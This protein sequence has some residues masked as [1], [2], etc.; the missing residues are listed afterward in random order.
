[1]ILLFI[2]RLFCVHQWEVEQD[3]LT[4]EYFEVCRKCEKVKK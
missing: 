2:K 4:D 3:L 1:M